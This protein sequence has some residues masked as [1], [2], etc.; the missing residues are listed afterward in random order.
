MPKWSNV[1]R[2]PLTWAQQETA[3]LIDRR[4]AA[5]RRLAAMGGLPALYDEVARV[6]QQLADVDGAIAAR[7][8]AGLAQ[9]RMAPQPIRAAIVAPLEAAA[10]AA[11]S[12]AQAATP[13]PQP[14]AR[15]VSV[16]PVRSAPTAVARVAAVVVPPSTPPFTEQPIS[17]ERRAE[18]LSATPL[19]Q[20]TLKQSPTSQPMPMPA[21]A[22]DPMQARLIALTRD[23]AGLRLATDRLSGKRHNDLLAMT[24]LGLRALERKKG[25]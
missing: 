18:L 4:I 23:I 14:D 19:G 9:P 1:L 21:P 11:P 5:T 12:V 17:A 10:R 16:A 3:A 24:P 15:V 6:E 2:A 7:S 20:A 13:S 25:R 22:L 8:G